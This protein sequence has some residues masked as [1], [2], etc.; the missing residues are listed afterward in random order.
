MEEEEVDP[1]WWRVVS[2]TIRRNYAREKDPLPLPLNMKLNGPQS[3]SGRLGKQN[4]LPLTVTIVT[5]LSR[6]S[7]RSLAAFGNDDHDDEE[8][9]V[10]P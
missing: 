2:F 9:A 3:R 4:L 8:S 10:D 7:C 5:T 6:I 1:T